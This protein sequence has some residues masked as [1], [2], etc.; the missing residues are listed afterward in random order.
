MEVSPLPVSL[1]TSP[2]RNTLPLHNAL[3]TPPLPISST[4]MELGRRAVWG[5]TSKLGSEGSNI[6]AKLEGR[7]AP[8][9]SAGPIRCHLCARSDL[10]PMY[11]VR[12]GVLRPSSLGR[13]R[14]GTGR[15][16]SEPPPC[17][18]VNLPLS[19]HSSPTQRSSDPT[20][21]DLQHHDG[22]WKAR[23]LGKHLEAWK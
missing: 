20:A 3:P 10:L 16:G 4:T 2:S 12:T 8:A 14:G 15:N 19:Q 17:L 11:P 7:S 5:S 9:R 18:P 23:R 22:A 1:S 6:R 21:S 13:V